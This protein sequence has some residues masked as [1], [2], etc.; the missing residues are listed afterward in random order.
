MVRNCPN[1]SDEGYGYHLKI[2]PTMQYMGQ[3]SLRTESSEEA[4]ICSP[5]LAAVTGKLLT[6]G[7]ASSPGDLLRFVHRL[8]GEK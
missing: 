1:H 4:F 5:C 8:T 7:H 3:V 6:G 2:T